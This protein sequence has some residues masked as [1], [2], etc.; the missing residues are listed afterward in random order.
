[1]NIHEYQAK[2]LFAAFGVA[3]AKGKAAKDVSEFEAAVA[4]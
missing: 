1:M 2:E 3:V 4:G